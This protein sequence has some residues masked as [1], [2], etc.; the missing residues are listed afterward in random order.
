MSARQT[1]LVV[2]DQVFIRMAALDIVDQ[3]GFDAVEADG[4]D[5][6]IAILET[7][8]HIH[9]VFTDVDMPGSMDGNKLAHYIR[10]RW[11][12][13]MLIVVSGKTIIAGSDL[14]A[15]AKFFS[16]PYSD[17]AIA[18]AMVKMLAPAVG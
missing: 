3:A 10:E 9:L 4:A 17:D 16:K 18:E 1:V 12:S 6:A 8:Q 14:P 7:R 15:G 13:I 5:R 2:K 11:P